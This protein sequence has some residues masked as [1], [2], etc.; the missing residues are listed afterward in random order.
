MDRLGP[1]LDVI[2]RPVPPSALAYVAQNLLGSLEIFH[3][4]GF[5]HRDIKPQNILLSSVEKTF[6]DMVL[7]DYGLSTVIKNADSYGIGRGLKGTVKYSSISTH[8]GVEQNV[9][10][11]LQSVGYVLLHLAGADL[12]WKTVSKDS[13]KKRSYHKILCHKLST[14]TMELT[15]DL[16]ASIKTVLAEF[17][18]YVSSLAFHSRPSYRYMKTLFAP[19]A[20]EFGGS[21]II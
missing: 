13:D 20:A 16:D 7:I 12:P 17:L 9:R 5:V 8:L 15:A 18:Y 2:R 3:S 11:D 14:N 21:F 19:S 10:D 1:S 6:P 4:K